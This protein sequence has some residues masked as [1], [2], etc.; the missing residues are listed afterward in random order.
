MVLAP[1]IN[2]GHASFLYKEGTVRKFPTHL[3]IGDAEYCVH[4]VNELDKNL[5]G[6]C[7]QHAKFIIVSPN[8]SAEEI[9]KT[10][11]HECLH[12]IE[13]EF[14]VTLGHPKIKKLEIALAQLNDQLYERPRRK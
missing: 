3:K 4:F 9:H 13:K 5:A 11:L 2:L 1:W 7:S 12:A 6:I 10:L 14:K 8:Q